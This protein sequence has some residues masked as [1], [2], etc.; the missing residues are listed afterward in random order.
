MDHGRLFIA[1]DSLT[2]QLGRLYIGEGSLTIH[3]RAW[4]QL[5]PSWLGQEGSMLFPH[6]KEKLQAECSTKMLVDDN[7]S[8]E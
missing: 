2:S 5:L 3:H 4:Y 7:W 6:G 1:E 8:V